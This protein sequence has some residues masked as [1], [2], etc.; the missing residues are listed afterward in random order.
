MCEFQ[1]LETSHG[2]WPMGREIAVEERLLLQ[3]TKC[4]GWVVLFLLV[5]TH[6]ENF[7][8]PLFVKFWHKW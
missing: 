7:C 2:K 8:S 4:G 6:P 1:R 5:V 3:T